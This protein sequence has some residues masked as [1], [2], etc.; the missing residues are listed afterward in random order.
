MERSFKIF[1][2]GPSIKFGPAFGRWYVRVVARRPQFDREAVVRQA[3]EVFWIDG[4]QGASMSRLSEAMGLGP[5]SIYAAFGSKEGLFREAL[6]IYVGD[7]RR[8]VAKVDRP[9]KALLTAWFR[10]HIESAS[11]GQRGCLLLNST[12][13]SPRLDRESQTAV[14]DE[15]DTLE[16]FFNECVAGARAQSPNAA[17]RATARLLVAALA[18]IST[19]SRA[20]IGKAALKDIADTALASV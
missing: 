7:I 1:L 11:N 16:A 17:S 6:E 3:M 2:N 15:V 13:E 8:R 14:R 12:A 4:Y 5:G 20:G 19:M 9:P 10:A 18:G